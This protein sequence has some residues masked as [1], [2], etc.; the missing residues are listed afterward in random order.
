MVP[1]LASSTLMWNASLKEMFC[2]I[3]ENGLAGMEFWAQHFFYQEY[4][5]TEYVRLAG[6]YPM[7]TVIHSCSWDLNLSSVNEGI[8]QTSVKEVIASM[9]L[10]RKL[11]ASEITVHPGHMTTTCCRS[12]CAVIMYDSFQEIAGASVRLGIPVSLEIMEKTPKEFVT[13]IE[14][15]Q[16]VTRD[17]FDFFS[18]TLDVAHCDNEEEAL[19]ILNHLSS[20]SKLHISNRQGSRYHTPLS[21]GDYDFVSLLPVLCA[22]G[23]PMVVEGYDPGRYFHVLHQNIAFLQSQGGI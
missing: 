6:Q 23:L 12:E 16:E 11:G 14:V 1:I 9:E 3:V 13:D 18:Y 2:Q 8:R 7:Q 17:L 5:E 20:I 21:D 22:Y 4:D 10:A 19:Y 15:M